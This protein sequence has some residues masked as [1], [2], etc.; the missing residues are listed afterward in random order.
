MEHLGFNAVY[1]K[2]Y[3]KKLI[4]T[5]FLNIFETNLSRYESIVSTGLPGN[6]GN[7][8]SSMFGELS[9]LELPKMVSSLL[10]ST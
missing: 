5:F 2:C 3:Y 10:A 1:E 8:F 9:D 7:L 4:C 6:L